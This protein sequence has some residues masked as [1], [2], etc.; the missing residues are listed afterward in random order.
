MEHG[1]KGRR[2]RDPPTR[3]AIPRFRDYRPSAGAAV[4][5]AHREVGREWQVLLFRCI[6]SPDFGTKSVVK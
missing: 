5:F 4:L 3:D 6:I 1:T 2:K